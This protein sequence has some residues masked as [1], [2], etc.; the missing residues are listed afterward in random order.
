MIKPSEKTSGTKQRKWYKLYF[1]KLKTIN[2]YHTEDK[3]IKLLCQKDYIA[4][5]FEKKVFF[6]EF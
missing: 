6:S 5:C 3:I 4:N 2:N 1:M